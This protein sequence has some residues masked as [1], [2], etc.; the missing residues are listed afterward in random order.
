MIRA[1]RDRGLCDQLSSSPPSRLAR[2]TV[3][4]ARLSRS[5]RRETTTPFGE[6]SP[7][8]RQSAGLKTRSEGLLRIHHSLTSASLPLLTVRVIPNR[9]RIFKLK[10]SMCRR[11]NSQRLKFTTNSK[12]KANRFCWCQRL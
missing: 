5:L 10:D 8:D 7:R 3:K 12:A 2:T 1:R 6:S 9:S 11:Q 4:T